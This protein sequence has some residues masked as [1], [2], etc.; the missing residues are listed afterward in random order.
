MSSGLLGRGGPWAWEGLEWS[1]GQEGRG[2]GVG[3][4][5]CEPLGQDSQESQEGVTGEC[6]RSP[7]QL[8]RFCHCA[9]RETQR[10]HEAA[11]LV[12]GHDA[13]LGNSWAAIEAQAVG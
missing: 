6:L 12:R 11:L 7:W 5:D 9:R 8:V 1:R 10:S 4:R 13:W 3:R 2:S